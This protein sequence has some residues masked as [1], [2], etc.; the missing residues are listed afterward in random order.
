MPAILPAAVALC[1]M[2]TVASRATLTAGENVNYAYRLL[3]S[4]DQPLL[5]AINGLS[6]VSYLV[7]LNGCVIITMLIPTAS[8]LRRF[9]KLS[10]R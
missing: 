5:N 3:P 8:I 2:L 6:P 9:A 4:V 1:L 10:G 7:V